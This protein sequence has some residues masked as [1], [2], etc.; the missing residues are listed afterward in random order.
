MTAEEAVN[1][2]RFHHQWTP[3][4]VF[5]EPDCLTSNTREGLTA[6]GHNLEERDYIGRVEAILITDDGKIEVAADI[7][8]DDWAMGY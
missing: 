3:D 8:G 5:L 7:R 6:M 2:C 1:A 4:L